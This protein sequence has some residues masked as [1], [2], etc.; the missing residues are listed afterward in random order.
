MKTMMI[1][2][3]SGIA[4]STV[5]SKQI[6]SFL[7]KEGLDKKVKV[8][9]GSVAEGM[10]RD[11]IDFIVSTSVVKNAKVKVISGLPLLTGFGKEKVF[12]AIQAE[13]E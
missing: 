7:Q 5:A 10:K 2:C 9:Q 1:C 12:A 11:D 8:L 13:L 3:G 4:T 6:E